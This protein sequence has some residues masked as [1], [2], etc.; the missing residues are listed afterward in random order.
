MR[1]F[2]DFQET[3]SPYFEENYNPENVMLHNF[4]KTISDLNSHNVDFEDV[5]KM[6]LTL[7]Y[8]YNTREGSFDVCVKRDQKILFCGCSHRAGYN[9][10][11][12]ME[13]SDSD[14]ND[15]YLLFKRLNNKL[16]TCV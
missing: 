14:K 8:G 7:N 2:E 3:T 12:G 11:W 6:G 4:V 10:Y 15:V 5:S 13:I 16:K 9:C 1:T